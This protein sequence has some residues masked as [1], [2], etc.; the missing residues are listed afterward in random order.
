M[1]RTFSRPLLALALAFPLAFALAACDDECSRVCPA[2]QA[3]VLDSGQELCLAAS[4]GGQACAPGTVC[5]DN[6]CVS[7]ASC[8]GCTSGQH[9]VSG[10]CVDDYTGA[11]VCDP[12]R[13][14]RRG[15]GTGARCL[16][17]CEDDQSNTCT[18][19]LDIVAA[20]ESAQSCDS[21]AVNNCCETEFC[22]CFPSAPGCGNVSDCF[23]CQADCDGDTSCFNQCREADLACNLCLQPFDDCVED[24][25]GDRS[26]CVPQLCDCLDSDLEPDCL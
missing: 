20:C 19:C 14:C 5:Q 12:L 11:N 4:C 2:G 9:C 13:Q 22:D 8:T 25:G 17:A 1:L 24:N 16:D 26:Q 10:V 3:C 6:Q 18:E 7:D 23:E 21:G 15:C